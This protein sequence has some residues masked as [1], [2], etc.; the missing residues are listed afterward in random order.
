MILSVVLHSDDNLQK[1]HKKLRII[2]TKI[3][4][5]PGIS[6]NCM[7]IGINL[8]FYPDDPYLFVVLS[9]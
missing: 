1:Q 3:R 4:S 9:G 2:R 8:D 7:T 6:M 5:Y